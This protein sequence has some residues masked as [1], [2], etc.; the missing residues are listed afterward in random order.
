MVRSRAAMFIAVRSRAPCRLRLSRYSAN[1]RISFFVNS[2]SNR[3]CLRHFL[4]LLVVP[5]GSPVFVASMTAIRSCGQLILEISI[6]MHA[7]WRGVCL[8][9]ISSI[10]WCHASMSMFIFCSMVCVGDVGIVTV[11]NASLPASSSVS[12]E[13]VESVMSLSES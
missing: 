1:S 13:L 4:R 2:M 8:G 10:F 11:R 5:G 12:D 6:R 7:Y 3:A 9:G